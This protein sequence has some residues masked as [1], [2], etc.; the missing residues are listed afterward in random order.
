MPF[1]PLKKIKALAESSPVYLR[2]VHGYNAGWVRAFTESVSPFYPCFLTARTVEEDGK[3]HAV[4][5]GFDEQGELEYFA[6]DCG[7]FHPREGACKH[8]VA[9]LVHKYYQDMVAQLPTAA[10]LERTQERN[11]D[12]AARQ[13]IDR[14]MAEETRRQQA[15]GAADPVALNP[16]LVLEGGRPAL[17]F[18]IGRARPYLLKNLARFA[19]RMQQE[20]TAEYGKQLTLYHHPDSFLPESRPVL[21]FLLAEW[22]DRGA[23][24][25]ATAGE[26]PLSA[27]GVDRFFA[28]MEGRPLTLRTAT[29]DRTLRLTRE[30]PRLPVTFTRERGGVR[31]SGEDVTLIRG[32]RTLYLLQGNC[33]IRTDSDYGRRMTGFLQVLHRAP[34]GFFVSAGELP[35]FCAGVWKT[36]E[37][38]ILPQGDADA[39]E[40][41]RPRP[42]EA[43]IYLDAPEPGCITARV[44]YH[45]GDTVLL[46]FAGAA[47]PR[48]LWQDPLGE[49]RVKAAVT[50]Q[51]TALQPETGLLVFRGDDGALFRFLTEGAAQL[52]QVAAVYASDR[53][54]RIAPAAPG[55]LQVGVSLLG[56]LLQVELDAADWEPADLTGIM[57]GY[58]RRESYHRLRDGRFV[59]LDDPALLGL[60]EMTD[61]LAVT[62]REWSSGRITLPRYRALYLD[63]VL[64]DREGVYLRRD[65]ALRELVSRSR[66]A[67]ENEYPLPESLRSVL[68][69]YQQHGY[70]WLRTMEELG[71]G[72]IL[73]DDMGLG[74]TL[75]VIA[76]LLAA[77]EQGGDRR[78]SLVVCPTSLV[79]SWER[80]IQRFAPA[81]RALCIVGDA[82]ARQAL[83]E[84]T[85]G[86]DVL[87]TSYDMLKRDVALYRGLEFHYHILDE[88]QYIKNS[89]TQNA[90]AVKAIRSAQ[91]FALTGTP[92]ENRLSELWSI[93][94]FLMPGLLFRYGR[95]RERFEV[96]IVRQGDE[97]A[98]AR[99]SRMTA[100]FIL[101]RLKRDV[102]TELP[103]KTERLLPATMENAQRQVYRDTMQELRRQLEDSRD[104]RF[105][106]QSRI[107]ALALLTR[108]RQICCD[109]R[110]CC[111]GYTGESCKLE[112]CVELLKEAAAG[113]HKVL[114]FSQFT[115]MLAL[116]RQ[117]LEEEQIGC[118]VLQGSTSKEQRAALVDA[119]N[120]DD[121]P[122]FLISLKAGGTGLNLT[123]AD[124]V[125]H[126]DP[127]WN[128]SAQNQ[129]TDRAHRIG[130]KNPVQVVRLVVRDTVEEKILRMQEDKWR[131]AEAVVT[132]D[133]PSIASLSAE[134]LLTLLAD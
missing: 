103:E 68:R 121:T 104:G 15:Q 22:H 84:Q 40:Q 43:R 102:L 117:R 53:Y 125:I 61:G 112:A 101:R 66:T 56:D 78:P 1:Y 79:L 3:T 36:I 80:E 120:R 65:A 64:Q 19:E 96:P 75:Q 62:D 32:L 31:V 5:V 93:F 73:A 107:T 4:E 122:V 99:L 124:M 95:F 85:A 55:R 27:A 16:L 49:E 35:A 87:L 77:K 82:A 29:G 132:A 134:E 86:Y 20:N 129:A 30:N 48:Q 128:L 33:L 52:R 110:L 57:E 47:A 106:G 26:L 28:L 130:Q 131:L 70:R 114:L 100:P 7:Q 51:F 23:G 88:A 83:L 71:F 34:E 60:A 10:A 123:G 92:V 38:Y 127:W 41:Y 59:A 13:M 74:K 72:G 109:P 67:T 2:G 12:P 14:Y 37:P 21:D 126:Y 8:V 94:D 18:T 42:L 17:R 24:M 116:I 39:L 50:R 76:L 6:C 89:S 9:V 115:S 111:E 119:F 81:L 105:S 108:L 58:R 44:E 97:Q 45:Y 91:R 25:S 90:K 98:L 69:P 46:P 54:D 113:G 63:A 133:G 11:T 118:Y